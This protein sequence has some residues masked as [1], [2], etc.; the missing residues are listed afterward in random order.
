MPHVAPQRERP[1]P[2]RPRPG[3]SAPIAPHHAFPAPAAPAYLGV[4]FLCIDQPRCV[5]GWPV[6]PVRGG[7]RAGSANRGSGAGIRR[8][9]RHSR[10]QPALS[11]VGAGV[12][13]AIKIHKLYCPRRLWASPAPP[14]AAGPDPGP[15]SGGPP[16]PPD[17]ARRA[18]P[19]RA[20]TSARSAP[21][22]IACAHGRI[23]SSAT[24]RHARMW[25]WRGGTPGGGR[26]IRPGRPHWCAR[27]CA[28]PPGW[29][30]SQG[31][32]RGVSKAVVLHSFGSGPAA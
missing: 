28:K 21:R 4:L 29:C 25:L 19:G 30:W 3:I 11:P 31:A 8:F 23:T 9:A 26:R 1:A 10:R 13:G 32:S 12:S 20:P 2:R 17:P 5:R 27:W 18:G 6:A 15:G 16:A 7:M 24:P 22:A 14:A